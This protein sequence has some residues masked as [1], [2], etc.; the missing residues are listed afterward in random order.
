[1]SF[2]PWK[3]CNL[4]TKNISNLC[5]CNIYIY[6]YTCITY[7][8]YIYCVWP[9]YCIIGTKWGT[10][11]STIKITKIKY[12]N[13]LC[14][15]MIC[16]VIGTRIKYSI[17][18]SIYLYNY[19]I[20]N[21][22]LGFGGWLSSGQILAQAPKRKTIQNRQF[23]VLPHFFPF[24]S[25]TKT[26]TKARTFN[27][28]E[29]IQHDLAHDKPRIKTRIGAR[30]GARQTANKNTNWSTIWCTTNR[31][32]KKK[33]HE[34]EHDL[35]HEK[36]WKKARIGARFGARQRKQFTGHPVPIDFTCDWSSFFLKG[37]YG[38]LNGGIF[39]VSSI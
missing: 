25:R 11:W 28:I 19:S 7:Y 18:F 33:K 38:A 29:T 31:G 8:I 6:I 12:V 26:L 32:K 34:L 1:M 21:I 10:I 24:Q 4:W 39:G 36:P 5:T 13:L 17:Q 9:K 3:P 15:N 23:L 2:R 22:F 27:I 14:A 20:F 16:F 30:F 35:V 37:K